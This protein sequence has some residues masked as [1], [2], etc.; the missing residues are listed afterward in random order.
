[1]KFSRSIIV[2]ALASLVATT[3]S[4]NPPYGIF[5]ATNP[6]VTRFPVTLVTGQPVLEN[7]PCGKENR[8][9][10]LVDATGNVVAHPFT[11]PLFNKFVLTD[12]EWSA[13]VGSWGESILATLTIFAPF[14]GQ[15]LSKVVNVH[16]NR[17]T[18]NF[19]S[20]SRSFAEGP[21]FLSNSVVCVYALAK[22]INDQE[23]LFPTVELHGYLVED[24]AIP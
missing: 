20:G 12:V 13:P 24:A 23:P 7:S 5:S 18:T 11:V 2:G 8:T 22:I 14:P 15:A 19:A 10:S 4:A 3:V 17:V 21:V 6:T 9:L 16:A 1:M